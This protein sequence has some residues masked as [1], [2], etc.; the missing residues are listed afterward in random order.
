MKNYS[1]TLQAM[2]RF[3]EQG[4]HLNLS[5][6]CDDLNTH[7]NFSFDPHF[8]P[9]DSSRTNLFIING[10]MAYDDSRGL[11]KSFNKKSTRINFNHSE[12]SRSRATSNSKLRAKKVYPVSSLSK[13]KIDYYAPIPRKSRMISGFYQQRA[14][15]SLIGI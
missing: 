5:K 11:H 9:S 2:S 12:S 8:S 14:M 6:F 7:L 1:R 4:S 15:R 10:S 3:E 13:Q